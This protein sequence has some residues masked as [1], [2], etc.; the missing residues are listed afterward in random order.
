[1]NKNEKNIINNESVE[2]ADIPISKGF[3]I[4][5]IAAVKTSFVFS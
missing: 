4:N 3:S 1:M 5:S 2:T